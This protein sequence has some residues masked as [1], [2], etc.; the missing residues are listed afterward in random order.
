M[1][2]QMG[3]WWKSGDSN[4][5]PRG[6]KPRALPGELLLLRA[7]AISAPDIGHALKRSSF[8]VF[9]FGSHTLVPSPPFPVKSTS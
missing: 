2:S 5:V 4:S 3:W 6:P 8:S 9:T 7:G 1:A